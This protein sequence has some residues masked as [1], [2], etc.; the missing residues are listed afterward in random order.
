MGNIKLFIKKKNITESEHGVH[1]ERTP[2]DHKKS[3]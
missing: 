3:I 1:K 2:K